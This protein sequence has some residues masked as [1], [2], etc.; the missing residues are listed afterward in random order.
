MLKLGL[1]GAG[2]VVQGAHVKA[3]KG[4]DDVE[5]VG[6]ADPCEAYSS[7]VGE[8]LNCSRLYEDYRCLL[9]ESGAQAVDICLPHFMHEEAVLAAFD[10][11]VD[12]IL[13]KPISMTLDQADRMIAAAKEKGRQF[14]VALNQRFY[15]AHR[16]LKAIIDSGEYGRPFLF[17]AQLVGDEL[18][19][20]NLRDN[21]KG[22][23]DRAGGGAL[24]DTGT[25]IID[26]VL[27]W[28]G[29]PKTISCQWGRY[30]VEP[31]NKGDDNVAVIFGYDG[32]MA[33]ITVSYSCTTDPWREW[34]QTYFRDA[35]VH[36]TMEDGTPIYLGTDRAALAPI[37]VDA[38]PNFSDGSAPNWWDGTVAAGLNH[39]LDCLMGKAEPEYGPEAARDTLETILL[40]YRAAEEKRTIVVA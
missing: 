3:L 31:D 32:M 22:S 10:A 28:F 18:A 23:W 2:A 33:N 8:R 30:R 21:W 7:A 40:A 36:V 5:I 19:R 4:R 34:K 14:Y 11:G 17:L 39:F 35:S 9:A 26:L 12:V 27:W 38:L 29:K 15:P 37:P 1:I 25:H 24:I 6:I 16:K 13:E 20:M